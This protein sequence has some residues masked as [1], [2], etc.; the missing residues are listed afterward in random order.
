MFLLMAVHMAKSKGKKSKIKFHVKVVISWTGRTKKTKF[1]R[2]NT[3]N[4]FDH[5]KRS[6][7]LKSGRN[8]MDFYFECRD[9]SFV[10]LAQE[11]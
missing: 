8:E 2:K 4:C 7:I 3:N 1:Y 6:P 9:L 11:G 10:Y 5:Q